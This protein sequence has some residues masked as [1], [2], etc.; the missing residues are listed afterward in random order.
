MNKLFADLITEYV[1]NYKKLKH[2]ETD[3]RRPVIG[4]ADARDILFPKLKEII[5]PNHALPSDIVPNAKSVI[6]FFLPFSKEIVKSN[7]DQEISLW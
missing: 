4:F 5:G 1:K 7:I 2:T 6:V 3:W